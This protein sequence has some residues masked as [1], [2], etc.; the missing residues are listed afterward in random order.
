M[1]EIKKGYNTTT[2]ELQIRPVLREILPIFQAVAPSL[3]PGC[4]AAR[5]FHSEIIWQFA[6]SVGD[7]LSCFGIICPTNSLVLGLF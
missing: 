2:H 5:K 4:F 7:Y 1:F 3:Q 6:F